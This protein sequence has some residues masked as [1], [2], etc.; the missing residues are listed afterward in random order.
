MRATCSI[1]LLTLVLGPGCGA[2]Y[3]PLTHEPPRALEQYH[4]AVDWSSAGEEASQVLSAYLQV[5]TINPP[6]LE[7][8]GAEFL[9]EVLRRE[10][11]E[12]EIHEFAPGRGSLV[13]RLRGSGDEPPMCLMS[14]IDVVT[15]EDEHWDEGK[16]PLSGT[17]DDDG[18]I[19]GRGALDMKGMGVLEL[20]TMVWAK[21]LDLPLQRDIILLAVADEEIDNSG[22][23]QMVDEHWDELGCG[24]MINEG[25]F[26]VLDVFFEGQ[27]VYAVSV[28]EKGVLWVRMTAHG[29]PG[30]GSTPRD[31]EA[32]LR[33]IEAIAKIEQ[34][35]VETQYPTALYDLLY[36]IGMTRKGL[37]KAVMT[38][39][40]S[41]RSLLEGRLM[42]NP[43][44]RAMLTDTVHLT[45]LDGAE[46][47]NVVPSAVTAIFD[48][49]LQLDTPGQAI[50]DELAELVDHD[51]NITFEVIADRPGNGNTWEDP[52]YKAITS[53]AVAGK[54]DAVAGPILSVG[55]T[56]SIYFRDRGTRA[57]GLIPF[58]ISGEE[59]AT[60][61][62]HRERVSKENVE[63]GLR[64]LFSA[65]VDVSALE[66]GEVDGVMEAPREFEWLRP[67]VEEL[68]GWDPSEGPRA[69]EE[70]VEVEVQAEGEEG[71]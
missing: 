66:G 59:L 39:P 22:A 42:A 51:P 69:V 11:I 20:M 10:G 67:L 6:G 68:N 17:I 64:I 34:R 46:E 53:H 58:S 29:E 47:P 27:I 21:R 40:A 5:D 15:A 44:T 38:H 56:D 49:R 48:C 57:Y 31:E 33:L 35:K 26:G 70:E 4:S 13:A 61:H 24:H 71:T 30:H 32:P 18:V 55:F 45:G 7:T 62:G 8:R 52:F 12:S 43:A 3:K 2:R 28:A 54:A 63:D 23:R 60:M 37:E 50:L 14:H 25:G 9:A 41:V 65:V 1:L 36:H 19:W 16:G